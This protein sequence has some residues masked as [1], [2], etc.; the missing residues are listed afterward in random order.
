MNAVNPN[1]DNLLEIYKK[2][3]K[4]KLKNY[5][6]VNQLATSLINDRNIVVKEGASETRREITF[7]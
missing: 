4:V 1:K 2:I 3:L 7:M 6:K 5:N